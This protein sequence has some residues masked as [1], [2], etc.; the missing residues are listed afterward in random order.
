MTNDEIPLS[1]PANSERRVSGWNSTFALLHS[2]LP[3]SLE[4]ML[5]G[6]CDRTRLLDLVENF[7]M[8]S[9]RKSRLV[10]IMGQNHQFSGV[11][12]SSATLF[13]IHRSSG[14]EFSQTPPAGGK[15]VSRLTPAATSGEVMPVLGD[16]PEEIVLT[17]E[18]DR[19]RYDTLALNMREALPKELF[20]SSPTRRS[21]WTWNGRMAC[22]AIWLPKPATSKFPQVTT[23]V[24]ARCGQFHQRL[25][26]IRRGR[27]DGAAPLRKP[28]AGAA[29]RTGVRVG[30]TISLTRD[31]RLETVAKDMAQHFLGRG[32]VGKAMVVSIDKATALKMLD[33][34]R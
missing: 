5:R 15:E 24:R 18:A 32:F 8:F 11:N 3:R 2:N 21:S 4:V 7:T 19:S 31:D 9:E 14:R 12:N 25:P 20:Q 27:C 13:Q 23:R 30:N 17:D 1:N 33:K 29:A 22:S 16:R 34:V 10:K 26:A 6:T 28:H